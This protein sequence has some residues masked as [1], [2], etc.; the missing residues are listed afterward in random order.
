MGRLAPTSLESGS[1]SMCVWTS[2]LTLFVISGI[3]GCSTSKNVVHSGK[4]FHWAIMPTVDAAPQARQW[5][6]TY[7]SAE[8]CLTYSDWAGG[9]LKKQSGGKIKYHGIAP[10]SAHPAYKPVP[11]KNMHK[12]Q[13]GIDPKFKIIG[14]VMRNQRRK[15]YP[16]LFK[17]FREFLDRAR[18][19]R[20]LSFTATHPIPI[21]GGTFQS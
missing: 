13:H 7:A 14:T 2:C 3:F 6:A 10:P 16:D 4:Y 11:D 18:K 17:A 9:V 8:A 19:S 15:L 20:L 1:L 5:I 12:L 21:W